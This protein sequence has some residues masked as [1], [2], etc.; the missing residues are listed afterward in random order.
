MFL[1]VFIQH[2]KIDYSFYFYNINIIG[3]MI[4]SEPNDNDKKWACYIA[5][6]VVVFVIFIIIFL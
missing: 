6:I 1:H 5:A 3:T 2:Q 4:S